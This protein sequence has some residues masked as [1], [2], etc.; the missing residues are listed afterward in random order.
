MEGGCGTESVSDKQLNSL[1]NNFMIRRMDPSVV[2]VKGLRQLAGLSHEGSNY[3]P[4]E[5][6]SSKPQLDDDI[7]VKS[8]LFRMVGIDRIDGKGAALNRNGNAKYTASIP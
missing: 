5:G 4:S 6:H 8:T 3:L 1:M 7:T 2:G